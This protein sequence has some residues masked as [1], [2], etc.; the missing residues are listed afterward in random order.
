MKKLKT[1]AVHQ[2]FW[3]IYKTMFS[4][5][6]KCKKNTE[7]KSTKVITKNNGLIMF[8]SKCA[9]RDSEKSKFIKE[10]EANRLLGIRTPLSKISLVGPLLILGY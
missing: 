7:S 5:C 3:S 8:L 1:Q 4:Y 2:R 10:H 9:L 6:L